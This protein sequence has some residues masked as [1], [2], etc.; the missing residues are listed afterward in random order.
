[1][2]GHPKGPSKKPSE[3]AKTEERPPA[4]LTTLPLE[5]AQKPQPKPQYI[6]PRSDV[7]AKTEMGN[8]AKARSFLE[9]YTVVLAVSYGDETAFKI[10]KHVLGQPVEFERLSGGGVRAFYVSQDEHL[11]DRFEQ[12]R[13]SLESSGAK[14]AVYRRQAT[15]SEKTKLPSK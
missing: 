3:P 2:L 1:M 9:K 12:N 7:S 10:G 6:T 11:A 15:P 13:R 8:E 5:Y 14:G 4:T